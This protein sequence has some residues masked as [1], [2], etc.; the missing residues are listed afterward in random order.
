MNKD[1]EEED[2]ENTT[3]FDQTKEDG[4]EYVAPSYIETV[5]SKEK[6]Q[7]C[8]AIVRTIND[9]SVSPRQKM[10]L[11]YLLALELEDPVMMRK[12]TTFIAEGQKNIQDS[13]VLTTSEPIA[14]K[15]KI[16]IGK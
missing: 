6:R 1:K 16:L 9:Y 14:G 8:R 3:V 13:R 15:K 11:I 7:E 4:V 10:Y 2:L 12:I 5:L